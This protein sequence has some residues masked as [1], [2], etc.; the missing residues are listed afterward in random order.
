MSA[1][2]AKRG[3][4]LKEL[5]AESRVRMDGSGDILASGRDMVEA[6]DSDMTQ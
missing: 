3:E 2:A 1:R 6:S 5:P 4:R